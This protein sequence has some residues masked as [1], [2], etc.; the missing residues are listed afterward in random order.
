MTG[1]IDDS[2]GWLR[3][4]PTEGFLW[5]TCVGPPSTSCGLRLRSPGW[6][7]VWNPSA[8]RGQ[9]QMSQHPGLPRWFRDPADQH[10][11]F[12]IPLPF[13][14]FTFLERC[15]LELAIVVVRPDGYVGIVGS[16]ED[17]GYLNT[18]F[19]GFMAQRTDSSSH[20]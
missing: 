14:A 8:F 6:R 4:N 15:T 3:L 19:S 17:V 12:I 18:Y 2:C 13:A 1:T 9:C 10:F 7:Y 16:L 5:E 20:S 11:P